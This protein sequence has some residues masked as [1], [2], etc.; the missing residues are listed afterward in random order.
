M[1]PMF[2]EGGA[3][4]ASGAVTELLSI[5]SSCLTWIMG[6]PFLSVVFAGCLVPV[7]FKI[8]K[9]AKKAAK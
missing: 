6:N 5:G 7:A 8:I 1:L 4:T 9:A 2:A 3:V